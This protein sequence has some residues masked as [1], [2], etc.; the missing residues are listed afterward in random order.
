MLCVMKVLRR[1]KQLAYYEADDR[2]LGNLTLDYER[3][4]QSL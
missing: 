2:D 1:L 3:R 4:S